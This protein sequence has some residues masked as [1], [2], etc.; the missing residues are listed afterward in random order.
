MK[1]TV[2]IIL[3]AV[4]AFAFG[5]YLP[6]WSVAIAA[7]IVAALIQHRPIVSFLAGF[8]GIFLLWFVLAMVID[9]RNEHILSK[10]LAL[11]L[12]LSGNSFLLILI[13]ALVGA[14]VGANAALTASFIRRNLPRSQD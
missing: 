6:W 4:V 9:V 1:L 7:F 11:L 10:K 2:T 12:P 13:T 14:F 3:I 5:L 8:I